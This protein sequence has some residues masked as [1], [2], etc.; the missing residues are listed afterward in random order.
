MLI[1]L[2]LVKMKNFGIGYKISRNQEPK[3]GKIP[4]IDIESVELS[5][6]QVEDEIKINSDNEKVEYLLELYSNAVEYYS[7]TNNPK[8]EIYKIRIQEVMNKQAS[9]SDATE[10]NKDSTHSIE[11]VKEPIEEIQ[12][13]QDT[14]INTLAEVTETAK[15]IINEDIVQVSENVIEVKKEELDQVHPQENRNVEVDS[16][17]NSLNESLGKVEIIDEEDNATKNLEI[18]DEDDDD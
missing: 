11:T 3:K 15:E 8:Y 10:T 5:I 7:A 16:V 6:K 12:P 1:D 18:Y 9:Q 17:V 13:K 2:L 4:S 14:Q